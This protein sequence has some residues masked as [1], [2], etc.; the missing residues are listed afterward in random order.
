[1]QQLPA[2]TLFVNADA[3][4]VLRQKN[5]RNVRMQRGGD[6]IETAAQ[7]LH[8]SGIEAHIPAR[9]QSCIG[10]SRHLRTARL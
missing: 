7:A 8:G 5:I 4:R 2:A 3:L 6:R 10:Y 1:V 9:A